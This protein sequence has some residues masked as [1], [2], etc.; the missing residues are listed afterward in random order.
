MLGVTVTKL[1]SK[2]PI[3]AE[4]LFPARI[5][6][7]MVYRNPAATEAF[8]RIDFDPPEAVTAINR[9]SGP[10]FG[11]VTAAGVFDTPL[12]DHGLPESVSL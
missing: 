12:V 4:V 1:P 10:P 8:A 3:A 9:E 6:I 2:K 7:R 11:F 5:Q